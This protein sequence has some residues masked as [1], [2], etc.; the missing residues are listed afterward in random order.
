MSENSKP[1]AVVAIGGNS[2]ITDNAHP[3]V[4]DQYKAVCETVSH[5]VELVKMGYNVVVTHGNGPQVGFIMRRSE[6][7]EEVEHM[8]PVPLVS[9]D[10][11]TQGAIGYQI[12]QAFYNEFSRQN[13]HKTA[14]TLVT[15]VE[16]DANDKAFISPTKPI[17]SFYSTAQ[18]EVLKGIHPD[19]NLIEDANRGYRRVVASPMPKRIIEIDAIRELIERDHV[20]IAVGGGGIP[21]VKN[22]E[23]LLEGVNAVIDKDNATSLL[24]KELHADLFIISTAVDYVCTNFGLPHEEVIKKMTTF[25]AKELIMANQFGKGSMLPKIEACVDFV[26]VSGNNAII[27]SPKHLGDA[28]RGISGTHIIP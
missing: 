2:L 15:Q 27:T 14:V 20:V 24:A 4:E 17:G 1:L 28:V 23:G 11:D 8:H 18:S 21:V 7:A 19:W 5:I 10:A 12:Q 16:V 6:I 9:C 22:S 26:E 3:F 25:R 13:I